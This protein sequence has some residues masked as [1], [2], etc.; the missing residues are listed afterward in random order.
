MAAINERLLFAK[1]GHTRGN[2]TILVCCAPTQDAADETK[3]T[4]YNQLES[5]LNMAGR[6]D[7]MVC[8]GDFNAVS[9]FIK[10]ARDVTI[11]PHGSGTMTEN[12]EKM[13]A[14]CK[15][16]GMRILSWY[17]NDGYTKKEIDHVLV[18]T[19]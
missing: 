18:N 3:E 10:I 7:L 13:V 2:L 19:R 5:T 12:S 4:F 17:S 11:G 14:F 16:T 8:L 9:G 1:F 6:G 15:K